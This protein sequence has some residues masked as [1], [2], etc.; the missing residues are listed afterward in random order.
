M[1]ML[2]SKKSDDMGRMGQKFRK[3]GDVIYGWSLTQLQD[4]K[5]SFFMQRFL[6]VFHCEY[7]RKCLIKTFQCDLKNV[8]C[9]CYEKGLILLQNLTTVTDYFKTYFMAV[10][11]N[12]KSFLL[13]NC[14]IKDFLFRLLSSQLTDNATGKF[15]GNI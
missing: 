6:E 4:Q 1:M 15:L 10:L 7:F 2:S 8:P 12:T 14:E 11:L 3:T 13:L 9:H 5:Q